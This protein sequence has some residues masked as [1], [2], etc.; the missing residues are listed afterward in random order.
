M[1]LWLHQDRVPVRERDSNQVAAPARC[2]Q[3]C[4]GEGCATRDRPW[5]AIAGV[6]EL[7]DSIRCR[8]QLAS[9]APASVSFDVDENVAAR[10]ARDKPI[11][12]VRWGQ[13]GESDG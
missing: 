1:P 11:R 7:G 13:R 2:A 4:P 6:P 5:V 10:A 9:M 8:G 12:Q 3:P